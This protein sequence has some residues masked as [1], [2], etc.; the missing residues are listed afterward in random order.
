M[1]N[2]STSKTGKIL[3]WM[4]MFIFVFGL[5]FTPL[6]HWILNKLIAE[7]AGN[8]GNMLGI[9]D[10]EFNFIVIEIYTLGIVMLGIVYQLIKICISIEKDEPFT[11]R[12]STAL[13]RM[14]L[15]CLALV[16]MY[17]VKFIVF[18]GL[19]CLLVALA[20][21]ILGLISSV[22]SQLFKKAV[23]FKEENELTV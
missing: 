5:F 11:F 6:C 13:K 21:I 7:S 18:P 9:T 16:I 20:F 22:F 19:P 10:S 4:L 8:F 1:Q 3:K 23:E 2:I 12:T 15:L 14:A 17:L